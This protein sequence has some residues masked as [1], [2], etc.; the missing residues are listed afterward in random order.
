[1]SF[2]LSVIYNILQEN[3]ENL[4][5]GRSDEMEKLFRSVSPSQKII[6]LGHF[7]ILS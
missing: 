6:R 3:D 1:M 2:P 5:Y 4:H 7:S